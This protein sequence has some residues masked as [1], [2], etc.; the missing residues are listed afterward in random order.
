MFSEEA[1]IDIV[2]ADG[3]LR[4]VAVTL[5][6]WTKELEDGTLSV[7]APMLG[8]K[9]FAKN[10]DDVF[11]AVKEAAHLFFINCEEF[12]GGLENELKLAGWGFKSHE[13]DSA[14]LYWGINDDV[15]EQIMSTGDSFSETL[16][17][18]A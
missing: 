16:E 18:V 3:I 2:R 6:I 9:T 14:S 1:N 4:S 15:I 8:I 7:D 10:E 13:I 12:G 5:P 11:T 17:L